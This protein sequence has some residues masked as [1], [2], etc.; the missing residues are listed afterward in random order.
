MARAW[1]LVLS[2]SK[3]VGSVLLASGVRSLFFLGLWGYVGFF[4]GR[5]GGGGV[6]LL[7][8]FAG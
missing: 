5:G 7:F 8:C 4:F 1:S 3:Y 6:R 2:C